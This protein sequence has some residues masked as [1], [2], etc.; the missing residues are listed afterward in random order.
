M[1]FH[2]SDPRPEIRAAMAPMLKLPPG[3]DVVLQPPLVEGGGVAVERLEDADV[4]CLTSQWHAYQGAARERAVAY[5]RRAAELDRRVLVWQG[6]DAEIDL[7]Y[8]NVVQLQQGLARRRPGRVTAAV[9]FPVFHDDLLEVFDGDPAPR[10]SRRVRVG[11]C[12]Q[13][14]PTT[15]SELRRLAIKARERVER[16]RGADEL[17]QPWSSH[18][19]LRRRALDVLAADPRVDTD[20]VRRRDYRHGLVDKRDRRDLRHPSALAFYENI[21]GSDLTVCARGGGNF[22]VRLTETLCFGRIPLVIDS[23]ALLPRPDDPFWD[24]VAVVCRGRTAGRARRP[25]RG[26]PGGGRRGR[27]GRAP[28]PRPA[29]LGGAA[30]A[31]GVHAQPLRAARPRGGALMCGFCGVVNVEGPSWSSTVDRMTDALERRGPDDAGRWFAPGGGIELGFRRLA[32]IDPSPAGH[33]PMVSA[34]GGAV[35]VFNGEIYNHREL[36]RELEAAGVRFRSTSDTEV[37]LEWLRRHGRAGI[38]RL[39]GMFA[40]AFVEPLERRVL[41]ARDHVGIKPLYLATEPG[42]PGVAFCSRYDLLFLTGWLDPDA[43]RADALDLFL[44]LCH[45]PSPW[46]LHEGASQVEPGGWVEIDADGV[47]ATGRWFAAPDDRH[48]DLAGGEAREAAEAAVE[49]AVARQRVADVDLGVFLSGGIDSPLVAAVTRAQQDRQVDAFT[50]GSRDWKGD[51]SDRA[52]RFAGLLDLHHHLLDVTDDDAR[53]AAAAAAEAAYEPLGDYSMVPTLL[54]SELARPAVTVALS[55][56]GGD[57][58]F[59]GYE[60][61]RQLLGHS[62]LWRLPPTARR[63]LL[64]AARLTGRADG[65]VDALAHPT[66]GHFYR[67]VHGRLGLEERRRLAPGTHGG[68][69]PLDLYT[70]GPSSQ[71]PADGTERH[72]WLAAFAR[73]AEVGGQLQRVLKKVDMASMHH[74]LEVRVP[75]LDREVLEVAH[76]IDPRRHLQAGRQKAVLAELLAERVGAGEVSDEKRGFNSPMSA[77]IDGALREVVDDA[78][79]G[80]DLWPTGRLDRAEVERLLADHRGGRHR[81]WVLWSLVSLQWFGRRIRRLAAEVPAR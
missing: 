66:P 81:T 46:A 35:L 48:P 4:G 37:L 23:G 53:R 14:V 30:V 61:P 77:W 45:V 33:Q 1:R 70:S 80:D 7:P 34:D 12:G 27:L 73:R 72:R 38:D 63:G 76:R 60:R 52:S 62:R 24:E 67:Q 15:R 57:E 44:E 26:R 11:F 28:A 49:A 10:R 74:S 9:P 41:L 29:L 6:G 40:F 64:A 54:V 20:F 65:A 78:L 16:R 13:A 31:A 79:L 55:G 50:I 71:L 43:V 47:R 25:G 56:D 42:G 22:S 2:L 32:V 69:V 21:R 17:P 8:P 51:E 36:G 5:I 39:N 59:F 68:P 18:V 58:L 75:L 3:S 19:R